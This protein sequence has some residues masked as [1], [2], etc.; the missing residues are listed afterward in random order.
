MTAGFG[1][2]RLGLVSLRYPWLSLALVVLLTPLM[3]YAASKLTFSSDIREIFR[4]A[5]A[6]FEVLDRVEERFPTHLSEVEVVV[7]ANKT[8]TPQQLQALRDLH[9][10]FA[11]AEGVRNVMSMFSAVE[12]PEGDAP[13]RPLFPENLGELNDWE[14]LR[15][16]ATNNPLI[17]DKLLSDDGSVAVFAISLEPGDR[18]GEEE[19]ALIE[20]LQQAADTRFEGR[21]LSARLTG[22]VVIRHEIIDELAADQATFRLVALA[23]GLLICW[24]F[25]GRG[26]F[27]AIAGIPAAV[28][29]IWLLGGMWLAGQQLNLLTGVIP[30]LV[31]VIAFAGCMHLLFS[32]KDEIARGEALET[33]IERAVRRVGPACVLT[34][35]T[36]TLALLSLMW[37]PHPF[38]ARFGVT[39]AAG[40]ALA[41]LSTLIIVPALS[42]VIL[43]GY[44]SRERDKKISNAALRAVDAACRAASRAV[45][46]AP[47]TITAIGVV[48]VLIGGWLH[49][50]NEPRYSYVSNLPEGNPALEAI[51]AYNEK[52]S[53]A[54]TLTV[55]IEWPA[56]YSL[57][58]Y[59][60]LEAIRAVHTI[61]EEEEEL[62]GISSVHAIEK[63]IG[64]ED[65]EFEL[66]EFLERVQD[67]P[68]VQGMADLENN[69]ILVTAQFRNL[70]SAEL[71]PILDRVRGRLEALKADHPRATFSVTG[72][73]PVS[74]QASYEMINQLN[75][76]LLLAIGMILVLMTLALR[77]LELGLMSVL[78]NLFPLAT[79]G[80][81]IYLS[82]D[83]LQ[84]TGLVAFI[85][86][87]G[88]AVDN[89]IHILSRYRL[90][91]SEGIGALEAID[92]SVIKVGPVIVVSTIVLATG[93]GTSVLSNLPMVRLYGTVVVIVL[94]GAMFGALLFLPAVMATVE[95]WRG[96]SSDDEDRR[97]SVRARRGKK[98]PGTV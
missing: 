22:L 93:I 95:R 73:V 15:R 87:F 23:I 37:V 66:L 84:F 60:T 8:F 78:P 72:I 13:P 45:K 51:E 47:Q 69:A 62:G 94:V 26:R 44:A 58:S 40:T 31:L 82:G 61:L 42:V 35:L 21:G 79:A 5:G 14:D 64:G 91:R 6:E 97:A 83:G 30:T 1:I 2:E 86:G 92:L 49:S 20:R 55:L 71:V 28:A 46:A 90:L 9:E 18:T 19:R 57:K 63:W 10:T 17:A 89:T 38:I 43:R 77:S 27:V 11:N 24:I 70:N 12:R 16:E 7:Q 53:G 48:V 34:S 59:K 65:A 50:Q 36:T 52:L 81:Y 54:S 25:F 85:V 68:F 67:E 88:I 96:K 75:Q 39:G 74:A 4:S 3:A 32:I 56:D 33:A 98:S 41:L 80:A 29:V 76:S